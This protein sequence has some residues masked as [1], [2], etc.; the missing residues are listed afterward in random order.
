MS[1]AIRF[2]NPLL[3]AANTIDL[4][5]CFCEAIRMMSSDIEDERRR[6][7]FRAVEEAISNQLDELENAI[8]QMNTG[9]R[10]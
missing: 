10:S 1:A 3:E 8:S 5:R 4:A 9:A 6:R 2:H 7:A